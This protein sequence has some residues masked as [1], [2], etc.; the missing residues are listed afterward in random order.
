[1][2]LNSFAAAL[3]LLCAAVQANAA[4][5][6]NSKSVCKIIRARAKHVGETIIFHG[7]FRTDHVERS[8]ILPKGCDRGIGLG[9]LSPDADKV[10]SGAYDRSKPNSKI[11]ATFT[12]MLVKDEPNGFKFWNDDGVRLDI[13]HIADLKVTDPPPHRPL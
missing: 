2:R 9:Q 10:L 4:D 1:M 6:S 5:L 11:E 12:G 7:E 13:S 8:L 3:L